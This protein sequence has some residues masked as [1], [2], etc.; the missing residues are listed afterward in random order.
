MSC[1]LTN[2]QIRAEQ[3]AWKHAVEEWQTVDAKIPPPPPPTDRRHRWKGL[4]DVHQKG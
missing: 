1:N 4:P 3:A 2:E